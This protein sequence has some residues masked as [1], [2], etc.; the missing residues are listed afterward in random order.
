MKF[1]NPFVEDPGHDVEDRA[2]VELATRGDREA[3]E[4]LVLRHQAWI[5]NIVLRMI[6]DREDAEDETQE[7]LGSCT[8]EPLVPT[9]CSPASRPGAA[10]VGSSEQRRARREEYHKQTRCSGRVRLHRGARVDDVRTGNGRST[11]VTPTRETSPTAFR[12]ATPFAS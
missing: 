10:R 6:H 1:H 2:P 12:K 3:L 8:R 11:F 4:R 7:I 9:S 5:Y